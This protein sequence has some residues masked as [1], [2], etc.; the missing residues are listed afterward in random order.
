[1]KSSETP[2]SGPIP[3]PVTFPGRGADHR[4]LAP[5]IALTGHSLHLW[6][7]AYVS[8]TRKPC[9]KKRWRYG[10]ERCEKRVI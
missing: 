10:D 1:M 4:A 6:M 2:R 8:L 5:G 9:R 3:F 7:P